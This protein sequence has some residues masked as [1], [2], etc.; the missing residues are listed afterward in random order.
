MAKKTEILRTQTFRI[1]APDAMSVLLVGGFTS[2]R[3]KGISMKKG[4]DGIWTA[5]VEL[6]AGEHRYRGARCQ[7][8]AMSL[9]API[10]ARQARQSE[11]AATPG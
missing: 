4:K 11:P 8:A 5:S 3:D 7:P 6:P 9:A 2:W 10:G 1:K